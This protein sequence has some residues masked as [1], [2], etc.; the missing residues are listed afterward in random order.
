[1]AAVVIPLSVFDSFFF[2][3]FRFEHV[4]VGE[5]K[6]SSVSGFHNWLQIYIQ[7][8]SGNLEYYGYTGVTE[9][10]FEI[11][12]NLFH[13]NINLGR[14]FQLKSTYKF[15]RTSSNNN[16]NNS[17]PHANNYPSACMR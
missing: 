16:N 15:T 1:M 3:S 12:N 9:V 4:F 7:E 14:Y 17:T 5:I 13:F 8:Q 11:R 10:R 6:G 2:L